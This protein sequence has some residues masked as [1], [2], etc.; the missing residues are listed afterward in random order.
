[1]SDPYVET[2]ESYESIEFSLPDGSSNYDLDAQQSEFLAVFRQT[3]VTGEQPRLP[4]YVRIRTDVTISVRINTITDDII[5]VPSTDSPFDIRGLKITNM[6]LTN[7]SG[8]A[9]TVRLL[10]FIPSV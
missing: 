2:F 5:T 7:S 3:G 1:M 10:F 4:T 9:A 6:F 8:S